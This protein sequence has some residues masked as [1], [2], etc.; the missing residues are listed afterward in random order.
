MKYIG[1]DFH[2]SFQVIAMLD[3]E[4]GELI[5]RRLLHSEEARAFYEGL[6]GPVVV[7]IEASGNTHWFESLVAR[8]GHQLWIGDAAAI[9]RLAQLGQLPGVK[10]LRAIQRTAPATG[11]DQQAREPIFTISPGGRRGQRCPRR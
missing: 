11:V 10:S 6:K 5:E 8:C 4:T 3:Q 9:A 1:S 7:G 2:P